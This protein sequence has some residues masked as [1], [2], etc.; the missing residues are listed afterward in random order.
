MLLPTFKSWVP[1]P[2]KILARLSDKV[3]SISIESTL[4]PTF[5]VYEVVFWLNA[6]DKLP[7]LT[8][9]EDKVLSLDLVLDIFNL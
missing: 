2:D 5:T 8:V 4:P 6:G 9:M 1:V 7:S 3:A